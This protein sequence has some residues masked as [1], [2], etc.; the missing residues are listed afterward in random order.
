MTDS[1]RG[2]DPAEQRLVNC[3]GVTVAPRRRCRLVTAARCG[4]DLTTAVRSSRGR[5]IDTR[6]G[7]DR[8]TATQRHTCR[9]AW[10]YVWRAHS[11]SCA[12]D[13][14]EAAG[15]SC[16]G[17]RARQQCRRGRRRQCHSRHWRSREPRRRRRRYY[18]SRRGPLGPVTLHFP[19]SLAPRTPTAVARL[20]SPRLDT[21]VSPDPYRHRQT[22]AAPRRPRPQTRTSKSTSTTTTRDTLSTDTQTQHR[23]TV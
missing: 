7:L 23:R 4:H 9:S 16:R 1:S 21:T 6:W 18:R 5:T 17:G 10:I 14:P 19:Y 20:C 8:T 22:A 15:P 2:T 12:D 13:R 11:M 3:S